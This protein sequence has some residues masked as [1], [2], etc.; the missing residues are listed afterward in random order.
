MRIGYK[1]L[2]RYKEIVYVLIKYG[3][4]FVVEKLNME[5]VAY[6]IPITN[7]PEEIKN[8]STGEKIRRAIEELGPTYIKLGQILSTRKD[9]L[10]QDIIDELSKLR[11]NVE[12]FDT[13]L[14]KSIFKSEIGLDIDKVFKNF[15]DK[16]IGAASIGQVYEASLD[17]GE[18]VIIK[19][20][21]PNIESIIKSDLEILK[22]MAIALKDFKKDIDIDLIQIVEEFQTQ[23]MRELD[24][25]FEAL[26]A[27]KFRKIF[28]KS[29]DVYIPEVYEK[30]TTKR[31][32]VMEKI[33]GVK[34]SDVNK[35]KKLGWDT[36]AIS[37]IGVRSLLKQVF[38][39]GFFH[40]D[41]HPGNIFILSQKTISYIDFG[42][43]G[44]VDKKSLNLL[45]E[46]AIALVEKNVDRI[47]YILMEMDVVNTE[48]DMSAIRQDLLYLIHYYYD[49]PLEKISITDILNEVF[50]FLRKYKIS[51][52]AQ[53][54][55]LAKTI[56]TLEGTGRELNPDF[57]LSSMGHEFMKYYYVNKFNPQR[58]FMSSKHIAEEMLL[59]IKTIPKQMR[60]ILRNIEKNNIKMQIEDVK[61]VSLEEKITDLTTQISLSLV[62]ASIV[63]GSSLIIAS[64][65][66]NNNVWIR[67]TAFSGFFIS[68]IIGLLLVIKI[69]RSQY[70]KK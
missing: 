24:Y 35:I 47:I 38:E 6:K 44:I 54:L 66:I 34:L 8:M 53:L 3:F 20:Q 51:I 29:D 37:E 56:I 68:F 65:N 46:I 23:L 58:V 42:M 5:G 18:E 13:E 12:E 39:H 27:M 7:P 17:S 36:K 57:S 48:V 14:A 49:V 64:P 55:T 2:K 59:D 33:I 9:L 62:L 45:N 4:S 63:V 60:V 22:S 21:R 67:L 25:N 43:I 16:P 52:P 26:N 1:N 32:L 15:N 69:I 31:I 41:P 10:D 30:Y 19:I 50:R 11:D 28:A 61:F 70:R 40:A